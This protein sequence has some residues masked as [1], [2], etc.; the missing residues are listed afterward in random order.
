MR[1]KEKVAIVTGGGRGI[2]R[3]Y[4]LGFAREGAQVVVADIIFENAQK[5]AKE[6]NTKGGKAL[7]LHTDVSSE[8]STLEMARKTIE[9]FGRID[10]LMNNAAIFYGVG[11][12]NWD[13]W[14]PEDWDRMFAVNVK[15][16]WLCVK[17]VVPHMISQGGGKIINISSG[18]TML[19]ATTILPYTCSKGAIVILT[20]SMARALG[21]HH[22]N[23][24]CISPGY[25]M[26]EATKEMPEKPAGIDEILLQNRCFRRPEQPEDLVGTAIFLASK[27]ADFITGQIIA[28]DGG[29][30]VGPSQ[31]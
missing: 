17:A 22:I 15:G 6:I 16:S 5:V 30:T 4:A 7:A 29:E 12:K 14:L 21:E 2:G 31:K 8:S 11:N 23:V 19:A 20:R 24:N 18:T 26:T 1:L 3:A 10:I 28:V 27:D 25:T 13:A 9:Q